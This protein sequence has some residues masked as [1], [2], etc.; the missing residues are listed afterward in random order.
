[1]SQSPAAEAAI[2]IEHLSKVYKDF[3]GRDKSALWTTST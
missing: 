2:H 1:M 3:W